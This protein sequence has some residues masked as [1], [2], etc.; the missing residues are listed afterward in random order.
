[1]ELIEEAAN[2]DQDLGGSVGHMSVA[3]GPERLAY[4]RRL[5]TD[6]AA[7]V[8]GGVCVTCRGRSSIC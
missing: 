8:E 3:L 2:A 6:E 1:M 7:D 5:T 4:S